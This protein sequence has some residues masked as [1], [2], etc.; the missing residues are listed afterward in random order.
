M[1]ILY[2]TQLYPNVEYGGGLK[3]L[4]TLQSLSLLSHT[5]DVCCFKDP[6]FVLRNQKFERVRFFTIKKSIIGSI[7]A[8]NLPSLVSLCSLF[9]PIRM[10]KFTDNRMFQLIQLLQQ[11]YIYDIAIVEH[12]SSLQY[13]KVIKTKK[14]FYIEQNVDSLLALD[15]FHH[16][17]MKLFWLIE[18]LRTKRYEKTFLPKAKIV[19]AMHEADAR[20]LNQLT[21]T[22]VYVMPT[23]IRAKPIHANL[24]AKPFIVFS[25]LLSW[26][27]NEHGLTWF[28][29]NC[30]S[31]IRAAYPNLKFVVTGKN[32]TNKLLRL[33]KN[34]NITYA[35]Y[36][37]DIERIYKQKPIAVAPIFS[38]TGLRM[39][40]L[41]YMSYGLAVIATPQA[42]TS[43]DQKGLVL[44][45]TEDEFIS[46]ITTLIENPSIKKNI[47]DKALGIIVKNYNPKRL[48][49]FLQKYL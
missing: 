41:T 17:T 18:C 2:L 6:R 34:N 32:P 22:P 20:A 43:I 13:I 12:E 25:G 24:L 11:K 35:G 47:E 23:T 5:V 48:G 40:I 30:W 31:Q 46:Q 39:K 3:T 4:S 16:S 1:N 45:T 9:L 15:R 42:A 26:P 8:I 49:A 37:P 44:A 33:I 21:S 19:F 38:S 27:E 28:I 29:T 36:V 14:I 7:A 10:L